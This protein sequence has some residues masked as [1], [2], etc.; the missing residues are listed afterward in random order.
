MVYEIGD[1][2]SYNNKK[3]TVVEII[4][5]VT[6]TFIKMEYTKY[7]KYRKTMIVPICDNALSLVEKNHLDM[8]DCV[9]SEVEMLCCAIEDVIINESIPSN[10]I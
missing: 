9:T 3:G 10:L 4:N 7:R 1:L 6:T 2:V 5:G 8:L